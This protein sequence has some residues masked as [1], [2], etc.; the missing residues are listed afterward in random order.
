VSSY[1]LAVNLYDD[2]GRNDGAEIALIDM[3]GLLGDRAFFD[4]SGTESGGWSVQGFAQLQ[5]SG[6]I[7]V[8]IDSLLGDFYLGDS[9]LTV[10]GN[11]PYTV[12]QKVAVPEPG[13]L[14]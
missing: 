2:G 3:P 8:T 14:A 5:S 4:L 10:N 13:T 9:T 1:S 11:S 12:R 6:K 7:T